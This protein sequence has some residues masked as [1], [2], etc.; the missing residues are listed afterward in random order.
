MKEDDSVDRL[1]DDGRWS[2][3]MTNQ[4]IIV[5]GEYNSGV[6]VVVGCR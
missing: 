1:C 6:T 3:P 2:A 5:G 4:H